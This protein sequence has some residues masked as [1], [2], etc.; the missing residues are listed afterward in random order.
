MNITIKNETE[1]IRDGKN[2]GSLDETGK[3]TPRSG[4]HHK[5]QEAVENWL[6][7]NVKPDPQAPTSEPTPES[8]N[9]VSVEPDNA[10]P[11]QDPMLGDKTPEYI[12]WYR[13]NHSSVEF[14]KKYG[15]RKYEG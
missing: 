9:E 13:K 11:E 12:A 1:V 3:F 5:T 8:Q 4:L 14:E 10:E 2:V 15:G 6:A 7:E